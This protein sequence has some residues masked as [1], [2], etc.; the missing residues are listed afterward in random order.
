MLNLKSFEE[1]VTKYA[2]ESLK[3]CNR[4]NEG[5][6]YES[7][8]YG[9]ILNIS[10]KTCLVI[11]DYLLALEMEEKKNDVYCLYYDNSDS[12]IT[13][14]LPQN[15]QFVD[16]SQNIG[17]IRKQI[18]KIF[19][20]V[21]KLKKDL[22]FDYIVNVPPQTQ[23]GLEYKLIAD[24][25]SFI[26]CY[27]FLKLNGKKS[28]KEERGERVIIYRRGKSVYYSFDESNV[29]DEFDRLIYDCR[30]INFKR[31]RKISS[32]EWSKFD[33]KDK[34]T[35]YLVAV[36]SE[37]EEDDA[38]NNRNQ[39]S[40]DLDE[41]D[42]SWD[43]AVGRDDDH[44]FVGMSEP[45]IYAFSSKEVNEA[46]K[47]Y[48]EGD[49]IK[50][51]DTNRTVARR[52]SEW[53]EKFPDLVRIKSWDAV[54]DGCGEGIDGKIFRDY[55]IHKLLTHEVNDEYHKE[56]KKISNVKIEEFPDDFIEKKR[57]SN[58][59]FRNCTK[60]D[61][62][63]AI[64]IL[65]ER[66]KEN[67]SKFLY[68]LKDNSGKGD[69][70]IL[71]SHDKHGGFVDRKIQKDTIDGFVK[72]LKAGKKKML[73]Y[74][75][76]RFGKTYVACRCA[77]RMENNRFTVIVTAKPGVRNEWTGT[78]NPNDEFAGYDMYDATDKKGSLSE[79]LNKWAEGKEGA[80][81]TLESYFSFD[82]NK[83]KHI[84]L[85]SS[86][87][88]LF[89][90]TKSMKMKSDVKEKHKCF[91]DFPVDLLIIDEC[92][93]GT[94]TG[95]Y[96]AVIKEKEN[97]QLK[98]FTKTL[99][100]TKVVKLY[101][102]GTPY[103]L[104]L[105][106]KFNDDEIISTIGFMNIID[107]KNAWDKEHK[108]AIE[109]GDEKWENNPYFG[110][111]EMLE[112]GY[113]LED[114][115]LSEYSDDYNT[116]F[117]QLF[118]CHKVDEKGN[119]VGKDAAGRWDFVHKQ[120]VKDIFEILDG[121]KDKEGLVS[122]LDVPEI[123]KGNMC[124]HIVITL[125]NTNCCDALEDLLIDERENLKNLGEYK[126]IKAST[127]NG[128]I[129][130]E[131]VKKLID[132]HVKA[133]NKTITL[134]C[135]R[136]L[137][138]VTI[139]PWDTMFFMKDCNSAQEY[140]QAKF[141]IMTPYVKNVKSIDIDENGNPMKGDSTKVNMKPQVLFVD[142]L[143]NRIVEMKIR[144]YEAE[145]ASEGS[146]DYSE[147]ELG[148]KIKR[149]KGSITLLL[150]K[151]GKFVSG[152]SADVGK[153]V[154]DIREKR[155]TAMSFDEVLNKTNELSD[156]S[157]E[158]IE[159]MLEHEIKR[160]TGD[161]SP[162]K[163]T[164]ELRKKLE[165]TKITGED[166]G[167][168]DSD[169]DEDEEKVT[170]TTLAERMKKK[171]EED[172]TGYKKL[173]KVIKE[174]RKTIIK[175]ILMYI[176]LK[177]RGNKS[178]IAGTDE[179]DENGEEDTKMSTIDKFNDLRDSFHHF[180][181]FNEETKKRE[182]F[183]RPDVPK[184]PADKI[185]SQMKE[186]DKI[187]CSIFC[188]DLD[189]K[190]PDYD[191]P[192]KVSDTV[193]EIWETIL[194]WWNIIKRNRH[195][196]G[197]VLRSMS[198]MQVKY[199]KLEK[200][201]VNKF[202]SLRG[203]LSK[204]SR[205][206]ETEV[207]TPPEVCPK[208]F[209]DVVIFKQKDNPLILDCYGGKIGEVFNEIQNNEK[210]KNLSKEKK[211]NSYYLICRTRNIAELNFFV[212]KNY[213][214]GTHESK[215]KWFNKHILIYDPNK[216]ISTKV[217]PAL[218]E[219][220]ETFSEF[221]RLFKE[222]KYL[223]EKKEKEESTKF[224]EEGGLWRLKQAIENK[225]PGMKFNIVVGNP[226]YG[227]R[228][229]YTHLKIM[230]TI[231][232]LCTDKLTFIMPSKPIIQQLENDGVWMKM[233]KEA[234]C[235]DIQ[236]IKKGTF[237][238][239]NMDATAIYYCDR[240]IKDT[241]KCCKKLNVEDTLYS[242]V[243]DEGRIFIDGFQ[244]FYNS[245]NKS[246]KPLIGWDRRNKNTYPK[247]IKSGK[248]YLSVNRAGVK[249]GTGIPNWISGELERL[250]ILDSDNEIKDLSIREKQINI[251]E[252]PNE[253]Y[254]KNLQLL[255]LKSNVFKYSLWLQ[256]VN[257]EM[258]QR[259]FKYVP[260]IDYTEIDTD[261]KLLSKCGF[262]ND[263]IEKILNYLKNFE[264]KTSRND[265]IRDYTGDII[266]SPVEQKKVESTLYFSATDEENSEVEDT[267][268]TDSA[269][270][271]GESLPKSIYDLDLERLKP[272]AE[273]SEKYKEQDLKDAYPDQYDRYEN[274]SNPYDYSFRYWL[275]LKVKGE[276]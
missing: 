192:H 127:A 176:L 166:T 263:E 267:T 214:T 118:L 217:S 233:F 50:V 173:V 18:S 6:E 13:K 198:N 85:F 47:N 205:L 72:A 159:Y 19:D 247:L 164:V 239:T 39:E 211:I 231:L 7:N 113:N 189:I 114:F 228:T 70:A 240:K 132:S 25:N 174:A 184:T 209:E 187:I 238:N 36:F 275:Y 208:L 273:E 59:F 105:D 128:D 87:Q 120:D 46:L 56:G 223:L 236:T 58:E 63:H 76:M 154:L 9:N 234:V 201:G 49:C 152:S 179:I 162:S 256:E 54:L 181:W 28:T 66:C 80:E 78:V 99:N 260:A 191:D 27:P 21:W 143:Q 269:Y 38:I 203:V 251:L 32:S 123:K 254:A 210:F 216:N 104:L 60:D 62:D 81:P 202:E 177:N 172:P 147:K 3:I 92:H 24:V 186:N 65:K 64:E 151:N 276:D 4:L 106:D 108:D 142:F 168:S 222:G 170:R 30:G 272:D 150:L 167:D 90:D 225:W 111:P 259:V 195:D 98:E 31:G 148:E 43:P 262:S 224:E 248:Y 249:P 109:A 226:P 252:C 261:E 155:A 126:I 200:N 190:E 157:Q 96:G 8:I 144:R 232:P 163:T 265:T 125:P 22:V 97:P 117:E 219:K 137:T 218:T 235:T 121:S 230:K 103:D 79:M 15:Y 16:L 180:S 12:D 88:D 175:D 93:Y 169:S 250:G 135:D 73:M 182:S 52:L 213:L 14:D 102:S 188:E 53:R 153:I 255:L 35:R 26:F 124:K 41:E 165:K 101:L 84:M 245:G 68:D 115:K 61:V 95:N 156:P 2:Q 71:P 253:K 196:K 67:R 206:G 122:F 110:T 141:R 1:F 55:T 140:D 89:G 10:D 229:D 257:Q 139:K 197:L 160:T 75:V 74:A 258:K 48:S 133:G 20:K 57:Y 116:T 138:G 83:D 82:E 134:T 264:F 146:D 242:S 171:K 119:E 45:K 215:R 271:L 51:G 244:K 220:F 34:S 243:S 161:K 199:K 107:A 185:P 194:A 241:E 77:Q 204:Y 69:D 44:P 246:I 112:F 17:D 158:E 100:L 221:M 37:D 5:I 136:L 212:I 23:K 183:D 131:K 129:D 268:E 227:V 130:T 149:E 40:V 237:K 91:K 193:N 274:S 29:M 270:D 207:I 266:K 33:N 42:Y 145:A 178:K 11:N 94:Q 86:L